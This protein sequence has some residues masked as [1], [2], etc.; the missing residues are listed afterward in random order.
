VVRESAR[1]LTVTFHVPA[2]PLVWDSEMTPP[3]QGTPEWTAGNG[4]ELRA[5]SQRLGITSAQIVCDAVRI[6]ADADLPEEGLVVSYALHADDEE[7]TEP[8][9]GM[10][11]WGLLRDSDGLVGSTTEVTQ[12]NYAVAFQLDVP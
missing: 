10:V 1:V 12:S 3:H 2:P 6:T 8:E 7:R 4:F 9:D 11:R 5:G